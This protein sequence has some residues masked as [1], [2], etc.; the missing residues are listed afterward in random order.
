MSSPVD[1]CDFKEHEDELD[2]SIEHSGVAFDT[3]ANANTDIITEESHFVVIEM[4][5]CSGSTERGCGN[6]G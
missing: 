1:D 6:S 4:A 5:E 2:S 3:I